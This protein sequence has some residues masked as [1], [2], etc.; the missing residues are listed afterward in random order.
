MKK[1]P[2]ITRLQAT[3][4]E[5]C[6]SPC[7][8]RV[9][10]LLAALPP[11]YQ[12]AR[13]WSIRDNLIADQDARESFVW[14]FRLQFVTRKLLTLCTAAGHAVQCDIHKHHVLLA[15]LGN[16]FPCSKRCVWCWFY[17]DL[18]FLLLHTQYTSRQRSRSFLQ[19]RKSL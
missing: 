3:T 11:M 7:L 12:E 13:L 1:G 6:F 5:V 14:R 10:S 19:K 9:T 18:L 15:S 17:D 16:L 4:Q 8:D 2:D